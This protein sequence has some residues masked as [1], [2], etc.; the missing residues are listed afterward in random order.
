[1]ME[2][3]R[4]VYYSIMPGSVRY[5][6]RLKANEKVLYTEISSAI[7][8]DGYCRESNRYFADLYGVTPQTISRWINH[9]AQ[10]GYLVLDYEHTPMGGRR[11]MLVD[12]PGFESREEILIS[13]RC[14]KDVSE[15]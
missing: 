6:S 3:K 13:K 2:R 1:M 9:L 15:L 11:K 7:G 8:E 5:D 4:P 14:N 10:L 12:D